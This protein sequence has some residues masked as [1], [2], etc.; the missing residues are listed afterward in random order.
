MYLRIRGGQATHSCLI[1]VFY[2]TFT[3]YHIFKQPLSVKP[4]I[5]FHPSGKKVVN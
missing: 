3:N 2:F 1:W 5:A 4:N